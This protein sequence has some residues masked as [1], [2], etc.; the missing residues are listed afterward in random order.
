VK[1]EFTVNLYQLMNTKRN[2][3]KS[4]RNGNSKPLT[5]NNQFWWGVVGGGVIIVFRLLTFA[6]SL[7][8]DAPWPDPTFRTCLLSVLWLVFPFVSGFISRVCDPHHPLIAVFE[9]A[10]A[11][12]L[13]FAIAKDFHF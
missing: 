2:G 8:L 3:K 9:G 6:N 11:P 1:K 5:A 12:A 10:S 13:F 7:P 4:F